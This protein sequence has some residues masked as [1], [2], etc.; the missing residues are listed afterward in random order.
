MDKETIQEQFDRDGYVCLKQFLSADEVVEAR[1]HLDRFIRECVPDMPPEFVFYEDK[2]DKTTLK[3]MQNLHT[4]DPYFESLLTNSKA[5]ELA[6]I[7]LKGAVVP[8]N[9]EY[10]NK[11]PGG[12]PT[13]AHQ[14]GYYFMLEPCEAVTLWLALDEVDEENGCVHYARGSHLDGMLEHG[15][16]T[17]LGFS[18]GI[19]DGERFVGAPEDI[20]MHA[21]PGDLLG[22]HALT[23]H[24]ASGN[25]SATRTRK[26]LGFVYF[27]AAAKEDLPAREAYRKK[28]AEELTQ[29]GK[30]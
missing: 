13:P 10:F 11:V 15:R 25:D 14:D 22:H 17:T 30:I 7:V 20:A 8:Q 6:E 1:E 16:T 27:S 12:L 26:A 4:Q 28:L 2:S 19:S 18:Q 21:Q 3:Q 23:V 29:A 5:Q 9:L 24:W